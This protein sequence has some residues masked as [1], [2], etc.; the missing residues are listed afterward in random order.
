M[1]FEFV[2][3]AIIAVALAIDAIFFDSR[4]ATAAANMLLDIAR[5]VLP[6]G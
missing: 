5:R 2:V 3:I 4:Y 1:R 6:N